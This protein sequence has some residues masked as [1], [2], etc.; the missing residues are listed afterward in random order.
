M[1][2][3][4]IEVF[5]NKKLKIKE[6]SVACIG[7]FD[8]LHIGHQR[9]VDQTLKKAKEMK[10]LS[11]CITFHEDPWI[12][13]NKTKDTHHILPIQKRLD[14]LHDMG[15]DRCYLLHFD[16]D[17]ASLSKD[18]F[19]SLL[20]DINVEVIVSGEDFRFA[21]QNSGDITYLTQYFK[22][23]VCDTVHVDAY[24]VSSSKVEQ[25]ILSGNMEYVSTC[26]NRYYTM[27]G[28]VVYGRQMGH[29]L[30][31]P[32]ANL[33]LLDDY[34]IPKPGVYAGYV[35]FNHR[36]YLAMINI[37]HNPTVNFRQDLSI[38]AHLLDFNQDFYGE[39]ITLGFI[40]YLRDE[41][42]FASMEELIAQ[43]HRDVNTTR[44]YTWIL[45]N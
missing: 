9:L 23:I 45:Q 21:H 35:I 15:I 41:Q 34:V 25:A 28:K 31:F 17:M 29:K 24:K 33:Q 32:T 27:I 2:M 44:R 12:V 4:V 13:L 42:T 22:T 18:Q 26:L 8:G 43:L 39:T 6:P 11:A 38:E 19:V 14:M 20:K 1:V 40:K 16:K 3:E 36:Q 30:G 37:G 10:L 5:A 7:Y